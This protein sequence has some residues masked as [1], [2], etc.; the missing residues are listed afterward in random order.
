[1]FDLDGIFDWLCK[2]GGWLILTKI[3]L[4]SVIVVGACVVVRDWLR[5]KR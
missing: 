2:E 5:G 1:M 3:T 4:A